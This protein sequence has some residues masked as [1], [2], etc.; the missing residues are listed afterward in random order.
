MGINYLCNKWQGLLETIV[1][2]VSQGYVY[3]HVSYLPVT[4][5]DKAHNIDQKMLEK[6]NLIKD[7]KDK[8]YYRKKQG[9]TNFRYLRWNHIL[10]ILHTEGTI[11]QKGEEKKHLGKFKEFQAKKHSVCC[12]DEFKNIHLKPLV[13]NISEQVAF[14]VRFLEKKDVGE[15][16]TVRLTKQVFRDKKAELGTLAEKRQTKSLVYVFNALNNLPA[17]RGI[18]IQKRELYRFV[19]AEVRKHN[20]QFQKGTFEVCDF[21][22]KEKDIFLK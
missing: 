15:K 12:D 22:P 17:W 13:L 11:I 3:Y 5:L 9:L 7:T 14:E 2:F 1:N 18:I 20:L 16:V 6:Y 21:R 4:K 10:V 8:R 19:V